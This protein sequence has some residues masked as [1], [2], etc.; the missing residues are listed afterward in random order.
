MS[1]ATGDAKNAYT[2]VLIVGGTGGLGEHIVRGFLQPRYRGVFRTHVLVRADA[3]ANAAKKAVID[4]FAEA[5]AIIRVGD[6][7]DAAAAKTATAGMDAVLS[8]VN[9]AELVSSSLNLIQGAKESGVKRFIPSEFGFDWTAYADEKDFPTAVFKWK[10]SIKEAAAKAGLEWT[11]IMTGGFHSYV[12]TPLF[13]YDLKA[14]SVRLQGSGAVRM[15]ATSRVDIGNLVPEVLLHPSSRNAVVRLAGDLLTLEQLAQRVEAV[16]G[17]KLER[18]VTSVEQMRAS[19]VGK[20]EYEF[21]HIVAGLCI[22]LASGTGTLARLDQAWNRVNVPWYRTQ[23]V[24]EYL[25]SA[26]PVTLRG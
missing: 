19:Q 6:L 25:E 18:T 1:T 15:Q 17:K 2:N 14:N 7:K 5:G 4:D 16:S 12:T 23:T 24:A 22:A 8:A 9:G 3:F 10:K 20:A 26:L 11:L 21:P 13:G